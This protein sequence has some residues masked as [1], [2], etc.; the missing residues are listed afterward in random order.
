MA[1]T[2]F[3]DSADTSLE[4]VQLV[5]PDGTPTEDPR[6]PVTLTDAEHRSFYDTM[7]VTR[8]LDQEFINLQR[9]GQLALYPSCRGQEAAQVGAGFAMAPNDWMFP[10]YRELGAWVARGVDPAG[11]GVMWRG[12][13]H[14][15]ASLLEHCSAPISIPIGTHALHAVGYALGAALDGDPVV[16]VAFIGDGAT[17]EGDVHEA[18]NFAAV[19][20]APCVFFV[21]NNQWAISVP[22]ER[23]TKAPSLAHKAIGYGMPGVR[24]DGNDVLACYAVVREA[25]DRARRGGGPTFIE[26]VTYRMEAHTTS[27]DPTRYQPREELD[28]WARKD[29]IERYR[30]FLTL[31]GLWDEEFHDQSVQRGRVAAQHLRD[32]VYDAPD[33]PVVEVFDHVFTEITPVLRE[34][35]E[36]LLAERAGLPDQ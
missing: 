25:A 21:Q 2:T 10:Q 33:G 26:A 4:L 27:D 36:Q 5:R 20:D 19:L 29:P 16:A 22:V 18:L 11:I 28:E 17:S 9:Q 15:G 13:W 32:A 7:V 30:V 24:C 1:T 23:Q 35:R 3:H 14:G 6:H 31:R 8:A 12:T 34:Q